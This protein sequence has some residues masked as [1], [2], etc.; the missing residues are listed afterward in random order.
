[1]G[2]GASL[3]YGA[4]GDLGLRICRYGLA[5]QSSRALVVILSEVTGV[6]KYAETFSIASKE[7]FFGQSVI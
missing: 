7:Q 5:P 3:A 4:C 2:G 6:E 1:M